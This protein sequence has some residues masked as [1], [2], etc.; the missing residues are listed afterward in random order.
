MALVT[1]GLMTAAWGMMSRRRFTR[2]VGETVRW[3]AA[4]ALITIGF[5]LLF[6]LRMEILEQ[7]TKG[8]RF[9]AVL[10]AWSRTVGAPPYQAWAAVAGAVTLVILVA[11]A[12][13]RARS[14]ARAVLLV[15]S[16][17]VLV[18]LLFIVVL[19]PAFVYPRYVF[20]GCLFLIPAV[21]WGLGDLATRGGRLGRVVAVGLVVLSVGLHVR[22]LAD[23]FTYGRGN[24]GAAVTF[25]AQQT[26]GEVVTVFSDDN[27][28]GV[29][30]EHFASETVRHRRVEFIPYRPEEPDFAW[31]DAGYGWFI[32]KT[33]RAVEIV[34][35]P[36]GETYLIA[37]VYLTANLSGF[38][39]WVY[40]RWEPPATEP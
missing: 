7:G 1:F 40:R 26:R 15:M 30:V 9:Q 12:A 16:G 22:M 38:P 25:M 27:R 28:L 5:A 18:P 8:G 24:P 10:L 21:A 4:P 39:L 20:V 37:R 32:S 13:A 31:P 29:L 17:A 33:P 35:G 36:A 14:S 34:T 19:Q 6:V 23:L 2:V 11:F 3:H